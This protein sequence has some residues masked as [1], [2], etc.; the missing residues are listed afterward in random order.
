MYSR[1]NI[2]FDTVVFNMDQIENKKFWNRLQQRILE[3]VKSEA[4][5]MVDTGSNPTVEIYNPFIKVNTMRRLQESD[6]EVRTDLGISINLQSSRGVRGKNWE[7][8]AS[9]DIVIDTEQKV[10]DRAKC[11]SFDPQ[12]LENNFSQEYP[13]HA[14]EEIS[15]DLE[16]TLDENEIRKIEK[17]T[18][19]CINSVSQKM[20]DPE[21]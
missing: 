7:I 5:N 21:Y 14:R 8:Q 3:G 4:G 16:D 18:R 2:G 6:G 15:F 10:F 9:V 20:L 11:E 12:K 19:N 17:N 13:G 1:T